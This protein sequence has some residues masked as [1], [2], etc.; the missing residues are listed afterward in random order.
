MGGD[1]HFRDLQNIV[2]GPENDPTNERYF[3]SVQEAAPRFAECQQRWAD[4]FAT[5]IENSPAKPTVDSYVAQLVADPN[6]RLA[7][8]TS[9]FA[10]FLSVLAILLPLFFLIY[11]MFLRRIYYPQRNKPTIQKTVKRTRFRDAL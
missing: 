1:E 5:A 4:A 3:F 8:E 2:N 7:C 10:D 6:R 11:W 9:P